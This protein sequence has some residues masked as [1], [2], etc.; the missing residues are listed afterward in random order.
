[1]ESPR[2]F[3]ARLTVIDRPAGIGYEFPFLVMDR[4]HNSPTHR[5]AAGKEPDAE[6]PRGFLRESPALQIRMRWVDTPQLEGERFIH[7][8]PPLFFS[9]ETSSA[10]FA[11]S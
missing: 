1:M 5:T 7:H 6:S 11:A 8:S 2:E 3:V 9:F 10:G 4:N